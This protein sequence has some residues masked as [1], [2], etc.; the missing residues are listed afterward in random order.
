MAYNEDL[1]NRVRERL[2]AED[3]LTEMEMFGGVG[4]MLAGNMS[5]GISG[6]ELIVRVGPDADEAALG[7]P[8]TRPFDITGRPMRG[9]I[10]VAPEGTRS[11]DQL[12]AW[13]ARG[14]AF[15]RMLPAKG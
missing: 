3:A 15:A 13:V 5:V 9:W 4:F 2:R 11:E 10:M 12:A 14:V 8:H 7:Q 1:A 6:D